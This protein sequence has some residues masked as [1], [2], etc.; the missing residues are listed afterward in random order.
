ME[1]TKI[2]QLIAKQ[3]NKQQILGKVKV[4]TSTLS[5][6]N[7]FP[8]MSSFQQKKFIRHAKN[9]ESLTRKKKAGSTNF[10]WERLDVWVNKIQSSHKYL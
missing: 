4:E 5:C 3:I 10:L 1:A 8:E 6:Y 7:I 2:I 9:Q